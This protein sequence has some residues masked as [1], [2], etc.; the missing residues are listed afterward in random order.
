MLN[1]QVSGSSAGRRTKVVKL[2]GL[3][4]SQLSLQRGYGMKFRKLGRVPVNAKPV[5]IHVT[6]SIISSLT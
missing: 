1:Q 2:Q 5:A 6:N 4:H 3:I